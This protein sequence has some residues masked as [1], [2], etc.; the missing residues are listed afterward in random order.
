MTLK[1]CVTSRDLFSDGLQ[2]E[3]SSE[4]SQAGSA[5][6]RIWDE[7]CPIELMELPDAQLSTLDAGAFGATGKDGFP[8]IKTHKFW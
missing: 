6:S 2:I 4:H 5:K 7:P 3:S 8:I 1:L